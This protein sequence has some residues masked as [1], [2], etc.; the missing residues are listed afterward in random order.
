VHRHRGQKAAQHSR[1]RFPL[2]LAGT[3]AGKTC[4]GPIWLSSEIE[5]CGPGD[6]LAAT[7]T[8]DLFKLKMLPE[9]LN[10]FVHLAGWGRYSPSER[11]IVNHADD[12]RIILRS[13]NAPGGLESATAK[14]AWL[15][16]CGQDSF[17]LEAWEAV[18]RRLA[19]NQGRALMTT[20][21]YSLGWLK[22]QVYDR[23]RSREPSTSEPRERCRRGSS[24]CST[25]ESSLAPLA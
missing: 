11:L 17:R 20:T 4:W 2:V 22:Q 3:Q 12:T 7:A 14:A 23:W 19:L 9:M 16:E 1:A 13:A 24:P 18:Q 10:W 21:P 8:Y 5:A 25:G 6:Y 15:D